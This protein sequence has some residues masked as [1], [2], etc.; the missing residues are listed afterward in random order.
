MSLIFRSD[1]DETLANELEQHENELR[2]AVEELGR[3]ARDRID[4]RDWLVRYP[5]ISLIAAFV[6]GWRIGVSR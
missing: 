2:V 5:E 4:P 3:V 6:L 1:A